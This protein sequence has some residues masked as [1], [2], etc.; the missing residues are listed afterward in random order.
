MD[1]KTRARFIV[2]T[3]PTG[4]GGCWLWTAS[5][6]RKGYGKFKMAGRVHRAHR[7]SYEMH[8]GPIPDGLELDHLCRNRMCVNPDHLEP[9]TTQEN[10]LRGDTIAACNAAKTHCPQGHEYAGDNLYIDK[11]GR[12]F[13]RTC[14]RERDRKRYQRKKEAQRGI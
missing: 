4:V 6:D 8:V 10:L 2:K 13:C 9:V 12:R 7:V 14:A 5:K 11:R 1:A 3:L